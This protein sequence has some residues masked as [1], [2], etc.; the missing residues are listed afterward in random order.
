MMQS[1]LFLPTSNF[2]FSIST[3]NTPNDEYA[4]L[5]EIVNGLIF[6]SF[7]SPED[8]SMVSSDSYFPD[9]F[10][11]D[12]FD[13][14]DTI[15]ITPDHDGLEK[16]T[17]TDIDEICDWIYSNHDQGT[18][19]SAETTLVVS[20]DEWSPSPSLESSQSTQ[21]LATEVA[22]DIPRKGTRL[23]NE[24]SLVHLLRACG[25][26]MGDGDKG[27][28]AKMIVQS[29]NEKSNLQGSSIE[30]VAYHMFKSKDD[31]YL[32]QESIKNLVPALGLMY[33]T[34]MCGRFAHNAA[35]AAILESMPDD[36]AV[37]HIVDFDIGEGIQ[38]PALIEALSREGKTTVRL[39]AIV[40]SSPSCWEFEETK[41]RL[42]DHA[43]EYGLKLYME[44]K[45]IEDLA[46]EM[47][48]KRKKN[49]SG[50]GRDWLVFN[51]MAALPHMGRRRRTV[52]F[53]KVA[54][55]ILGDYDGILSFGD[56][57]AGEE[58]RKCSSFESYYEKLV[59]HYEALIEAL[60][61]SL[62]KG[63]TT[64][65]EEG[66]MGMECLF[67]APLMNPSAWLEEW[68][69]GGDYERVLEGR[70]VSFESL[71]EAKVMVE[72]RENGYSVR[73][74]ENEMVLRWKETALVRVST[75]CSRR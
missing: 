41:K 75:F 3:S 2:P 13:H 42:L 40:G 74:R 12:L 63:S 21:L 11:T 20:A 14:H 49:R 7:P 19:S 25:E 56:G 48:R 66:R 61:W 72:E 22:I 35:N 26:A 9:A 24:L 60:E 37:L 58:T 17:R 23:G 18:S 32:R 33:Q 16:I 44:E 47:R 67:L 28:L 50:G 70:K 64:I 30:R 29:I 62:P 5:S 39:T 1:Q 54:E 53:L 73:M 34:L 65:I 46:E 27:A 6:P 36:V 45:G 43:K 31:E 52:E 38:W 51:C 55:E 8:S 4:D 68:K 69:E 71:T 57:E 10:P 15:M 59:K